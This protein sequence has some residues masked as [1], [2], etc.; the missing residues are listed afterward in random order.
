MR[1]VALYSCTADDA[2]ELSFPADAVI[3]DIKPARSEG[4]GWFHGR[5][6]GTQRTGLFPGNYVRFLPASPPPSSQ[7]RASEQHQQQ[8]GGKAF[9]VVLKQTTFASSQ[10]DTDE[11]H[12]EGWVKKKEGIVRDPLH[13]PTLKPVAQ[14]PLKGGDDEEEE[15][16]EASK[17]PGVKPNFGQSAFQTIQAAGAAE[18]KDQATDTVQTTAAC[19]GVLETF[20]WCSKPVACST[21]QASAF[22]LYTTTSSVNDCF[23]EYFVVKGVGA[24]QASNF[25]LYTTNVND[26]FL[27][28]F[29]V[30]AVGAFL[31]FQKLHTEFDTLSKR[32]HTASFFKSLSL[33]NQNRRRIATSRTLGGS[34]TFRPETSVGLWLIDGFLRGEGIPETLDDGL[35]EMRDR[36]MPSLLD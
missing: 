32:K 36:G 31:A 11:D 7:K 12:Q 8:S 18:W 16:E 33:T 4:E 26:C 23:L 14:V 6:D 29:V 13:P 9:G 17:L 19:A 3:V 10:R 1:A 21:R 24:F 34:E 15:E 20:I 28:C 22:K 30:K 2:S 5:L 35:L 27:E 25:N